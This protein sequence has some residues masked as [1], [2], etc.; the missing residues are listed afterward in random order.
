MTESIPSLIP[1]HKLQGKNLYIPGDISSAA[2]FIVAGLILKESDITIKNIGM[3]PTR[4]RFLEILIEM[5]A[6][7]EIKNPRIVNNEQ[8]ADIKARSSDLTG[9]NIER[10]IIPN[11]IDEIPVLC[12]AAAFADGNTVIS[13]AGELRFKESDR[14]KSV[15]GQ[16]RNAGVDIQEREDGF[17][18]KGKRDSKINGGS[19]ECYGDHRIAMSL[20]VLGLRS[21]EHFNINNFECVDTSFPSFKYELKKALEDK[22]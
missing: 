5:G 8:I 1:G 10:D 21:E 3:N 17:I 6:N 14:I 4:N 22:Q 13:G 12:A 9:I 2:Y 20:A 18:I 15:S 7:I 11:I 16:F 19:F